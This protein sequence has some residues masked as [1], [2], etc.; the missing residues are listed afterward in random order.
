[1]SDRL[2]LSE[3]VAGVTL[4][5]LGNGM[6]DVMT[7]NSALSAHYTAAKSP[8]GRNLFID[9]RQTKGTYPFFRVCPRDVS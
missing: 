6:P 4:L 8:K 2:Q 5:A 1:M 9:P 3:D 7:A